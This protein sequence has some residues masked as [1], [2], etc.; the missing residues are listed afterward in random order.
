MSSVPS[1]AANSRWSGRPIQAALIRAFAFVAPIGAS[2]GFVDLAS[3]LA[4]A[5]L[6]SLWAYLLWWLWLSVAATLVLIGVEWLARKLLPLAALLRLSL[7]FPDQTPSRFKTALRAGSTKHLEARMQELRDGEASPAASAA[8]LLELVAA[9]N[10]HDRVTRGHCERVRGYSVLIGQELGLS[11][12]ELDLLNWSAL[13]HDVG[14]LSVPSAIL[15]KPARPDEEEWQLLKE[16]PLYGETLVEPLRAWL[17]KWAD[18]VGYHHERWDGAG[19]PRGIEGEDIPLPGRIVAVADV[20]DVITSARSYKE[21]GGAREGREE[22]GRCAGTQFDPGVVRA[23]L[24]VSIGRMRL[25][26]GPVSWLSHAPILSQI[27]IGAVGSAVSGAVGVLAAAGAG[28]LIANA[29]A[30]AARAHGSPAPIVRHVA[31]RSHPV[32]HV[33]H[34]VHVPTNVAQGP[35][36]PPPATTSTVPAAPPPATTVATTTSPT[37]TTT[38]PPTGT[39]SVT[40]A[41]DDSARVLEGGAVVVDVLANDTNSHGDKLGVTI[42]GQPGQGAVTV[43]QG[44][45]SYSAPSDWAG[46]TSFEYRAAS[47]ADGAA[48]K[49]TV[50]VTVVPVNHAPSFVTGSDQSVL[51]DAGAQSVTGWATQISAGPANESGQKVTFHVE[52]DDQRLFSVQPAVEGGGALSYTP[53]P[54]ANG[55]A[56]VHV[57]A[58]DDGGTAHNGVDASAAQSFTITVSPVNDAP[59]FVAG[60]DQTVL[61]DAGAQ[62]ISGW[63]TQVRPGPPNESGQK[64]TFHVESDHQSLFSDEPAVSPDGTLTFTPAP[65]TNGTAQVTVR[66]SDDGGT[67]NGGVDASSSQSFTITISPV[68]DAPSFHA[69]G[70][71]TVLED[72]GAQSVAGWATQI[73]AGPPDES[74]QKVTFQVGSDDQ[75]L[76]SVQP[77]VSQDG[78][79]TFT[80]AP[81]ASGTA[82]VTVRAHDDGGDANGGV[83]TSAAAWFEITV[84]PV[85]DAPS[86]V[87]GADQ[88]VLEDAG[89]QSL[90]D[91]AT[92]VRAGPPDESSQTVT[93]DVQTD[94]Q[95]LFSEQPAVSSDGTLTYKPAPDSNGV[96]HVTVRA[97]DNGGTAHGGVDTSAAQ[98]FTITVSPVNDAP[99]FLAGTDQTVLEDAGAQSISGWATQISAGPPDE[100][101]QK[102]TFDVESDDQSLFSAQPSV[103]SDGTLTYTPAPD[104]NG[105]GH[106]EVKAHDDGGTANGGADTSA[107]QSFTISITPVNDAPSFVAGADKTVLDNDGAQSISGWAT[108]IGAGPPNES[109][110]SLTFQVTDDTDPSL[111]SVA[112]AVDPATGTLT[113]T[114]ASGAHGTATITLVLHDDGGTANGGSDTSASQSFKITV[115]G[116]PIPQPDSF[117]GFSGSD[118]VGDL[119]ANDTD[120]QGSPLTLQSTPAADPANGTVTLDSSD[121]TFVYVPNG[122]FAG[123][124][125]FTY[126]VTNGYGLSATADVT[127]TVSPSTG[128]GASV[129]AKDDSTDTTSPYHVMTASFTPVDGATYAVFAGRV[130]SPGDSAVLTTLGSLDLPSAPVD[131]AVGSDGATHG[132]IWVVHGEPGGLPSTITVTFTNPNSKFVASDMLEVVQLGG[133]G[134]GADTAGSGLVSSRAATVTLANPGVGASELAFLYVN[135]DVPADP[136]WTSSGIATLSG[137]MLHSAAGTAGYG[138][139]VAYAPQALPSATTRSRLIVALN[140]TSYVDIAANLLP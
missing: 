97:H 75:S 106:V 11:A 27:P 98:S 22:I 38:P 55:V 130:S 17:G 30:E 19:Y 16:H 33:K 81:D 48:A 12:D 96:A 15:N 84:S 102:V 128:V 82:H 13:L 125:T 1:A 14:K 117:A 126:T 95:S 79:L 43:A 3:R 101:G 63:A 93:F 116:D 83:D 45:V 71:Q 47:R 122:G 2:I 20:Y 140:G 69:G 49:A 57:T 115:I 74:G 61:E 139:L 37:A 52:S 100:S 110:Q 7:V 28:G 76:F 6:S 4:P 54:N 72:S 68:N 87:S 9:L 121:G 103:S 123:T 35:P 94:D 56:H 118:I 65:D 40:R 70:D 124:D 62:S 120:P 127:I 24:G 31:P 51:E 44:A 86:F 34:H 105:V 119:L 89:A 88:T 32:T 23:F 42:V 109:G 66:A 131:G 129:V 50:T 25:I 73:N 58:Q 59:S 112:P 108:Q 46:T 67:A 111:F 136:G 138:A 99:S 26:M 80:P 21:A 77:A 134:I 41:L 39:P 64:T 114:P 78:T 36:A 92:Q 60:A 5:P 137:S 132:W 90:S 135:G 8:L 10:S 113:F 85:N 29:P 53:A 91:W 133:S 18:A 104:A 107:E